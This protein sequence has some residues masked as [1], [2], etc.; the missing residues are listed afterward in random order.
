MF[1]IIIIGAGPAGINCAIEAKS[2]NFNVLLVDK[3]S[4]VNSIINFPQDM[5]FF[6]SSD[7]LEFKNI[8]FISREGKPTR[9]EAIKYYQKLVKYF[10]IPFK[11]NCLVESI[12]KIKDIFEI[13]TA[14]EKLTSK[15]L[16]ISTGFY[17]HPNFLNIP[18]EQL[19]HV[20]HYYSEAYKYFGSNV[21][22]VGGGNSS[23]ETALDIHRNGGNVSI[24]IRKSNIKDS[25]KYWILPDIEN[26][27]KEGSINL[28][29]KSNLLKI[30]KSEVFFEQEGTTKSLPADHVL[31]LTGYHPDIS[32]LEKAGIKID[33]KTWLPE[34][35]QNTLETNISNLFLAGSVIAGRNSNSI[36]IEN[37]RDHGP[38]I[39]NYIK[40]KFLKQSE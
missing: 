30:N 20:S 2:N 17:D 33:Q 22:I 13:Q 39:V 34:I 23:V 3:G 8:P 9:V 28:F 14:N 10:N 18:G 7:T 6:S 4:I 31:L 19:P 24:L 26:R 37:S 35:N 40:S 1:D 38:K 36:F 29:T 32:L 15:Y 11:T 12:K 16:V 5:K 27:I 21:V 25:V